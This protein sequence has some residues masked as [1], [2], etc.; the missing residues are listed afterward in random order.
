MLRV[1]EDGLAR[2]R[3]YVF[4]SAVASVIV[5]LDQW[6]KYL[7]RSRREVGEIWAPTPGLAPYARIVHWNN[8]GA[9]FGMLPSASLVF[10]IVAMIVSVAIVFYFPRVPD[11]QPILRFALALQLGGAVGN[12]IDRLLVGTVTDFISIG[13][14]PVFN[15]A[16]SSISIG[17]ALLVAAMWVE[18]R[19]HKADAG[20]EGEIPGEPGAV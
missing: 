3:D 14:F 18:E 13:T 7:V 15:V 19:R 17:V 6:T 10:T 20:A 12:L 11:R 4:L 1:V 9:A 8:T 2:A 5:A 16:D